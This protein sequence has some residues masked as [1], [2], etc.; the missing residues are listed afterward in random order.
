ME[1]IRECHQFS[2]HILQNFIFSKNVN[3]FEILRHN[4]VLLFML[5]KPLFTI[6][7]LV[8]HGN[9]RRSR[10]NVTNIILYSKVQYFDTP[11]TF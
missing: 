4:L 1:L 9:K 6:I 11:K 7:A 5:E 3:N 2:R 10:I 8:M